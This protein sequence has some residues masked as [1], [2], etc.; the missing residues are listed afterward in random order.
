MTN[1]ETLVAEI[2]ARPVPPEIRAMADHVRGLHSGVMAMLAYGSCLRGTA[3]T[4]SLIDLYV[5]TADYSGVSGNPLSRLGCRLAPPNVYYAEWDFEGR[6]TRAKYAVMPLALF[7]RWM[8]APNPYFWARFAQ[9]SALLFSRDDRA[10][11]AIAQA[12]RT[13][14]GHALALAPD[15]APLTVWAK[16]FAATYGTELRAE[17]SVNRAA[18]LVAAHEDYY[19]NA[20]TLMK[21]I[22]P[23]RANWRARR[24]AGKLW[25]LAR[26]I[27]AGFTFVGG[28][29]YLA[30]KIERHSGHRI[31]LTDW[32]RRH[33]VL[34][35]FMLLPYLLRRGAVR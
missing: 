28:A 23:V 35:G 8:K 33:P 13:M 7:A 3:T 27:K 32:Q 25:S 26:L 30:W 31:E 17:A 18:S 15:D 21:D 19:R 24:A 34:A 9:P 4:D 11:A 1:L 2:L 12:V 29:D 5:L 22:V 10:A 16:G 14:Y 6:S 20:A